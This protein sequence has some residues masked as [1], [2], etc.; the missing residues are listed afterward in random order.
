MPPAPPTRSAAESAGVGTRLDGWKEIA[1]YLRRGIRTVKRWEA[2]RGLPTHRVP[3]GGRASVYGFTTELDDWLHAREAGDLDVLSDEQD[4]AR[5]ESDVIAPLPPAEPA[6]EFD[7]AGAAVPA[8]LQRSSRRW[9]V[10]ASAVGLA[11]IAASV[12]FVVTLPGV[13]SRLS[14]A[15]PV[16]F[17]RGEQPA[18]LSTS[19]APSDTEKK[20][21][22]DF[23]LRGRYEW[24]QRT[25]ESLN[26]ALDSFTQAIVHDPGYA[27]AYAG[28]ADTYDLLRQYSTMPDSEAYARAISAARKA[29]E[30]DDSLA[31]AHRALA[32]AEVYGTWDLADADKEFQRA[33]ELEPKDPVVR[34]WYANAFAMPG[35]YQQSL[36]QLELAQQLDPTSQATI[37]DKGILLF[38]AGK[39]KEGIDLLNEVERINPEFRSPHAYLMLI[40]FDLRNFSGY[41]KEGQKTAEIMNDPELKD[42]MSSAQKGYAHGG[43]SGLLDAL[44]AKQ[45]EYYTEGKLSRTA[46][47]RTCTM[48]GKKQE[49]LRLLEEASAH[50]ERE[51]LTCLSDPELI[52]LENEPRFQALAKQLNSLLPHKPNVPALLSIPENAPLQAA[53]HLR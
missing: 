19:Q 22:R 6:E 34:R 27:P 35:R 32:Y 41:L 48:M 33:I 4:S 14:Q 37:A 46:L 29:I 23:Y 28:L 2:D 12:A 15:L 20:L 21:A 45:S 39:Q 38:Y 5:L 10:A 44:Y 50:R 40:D 47:A 52:T 1:T 49:A 26:Q 11:V 36:E 9:S 25:P 3:G 51:V 31:E 16:L 13:R 8:P 18:A 24:N 7:L 53:N 43:V 42:I 17:R 30:L